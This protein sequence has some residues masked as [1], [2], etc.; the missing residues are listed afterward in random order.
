MKT[1]L[2]RPLASL[3]LPLLAVLLSLTTV[4]AAQVIEHKLTASDGATDDRFGYSVSLSGDRSLV[5]L[6]GNSESLILPVFNLPASS[7]GVPYADDCISA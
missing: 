7:V 1:Q 4:A 6:D 5:S 3:A 2:S